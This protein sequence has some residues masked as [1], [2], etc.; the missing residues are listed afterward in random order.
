VLID[1]DCASSTEQFLL[2]AIQS[3][4]V[5][6][7]GQHTAGILDY[8]NVRDEALPCMSFI[9][10]YATTRSQRVDAGK[11]IDN[12]GIKPRVMLGAN[13]DWVEEARRYL[14]K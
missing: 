7:M 4:K 6:L 14:E 13:Q 5:T 1:E 12:V 3:R 8:A 11:G 10:H 2:E 9:L